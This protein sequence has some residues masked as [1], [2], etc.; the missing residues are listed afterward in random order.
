MLA[1]NYFLDIHIHGEVRLAHTVTYEQIQSALK[2]LWDYTR[3]K[4]F[5]EGVVSLYSSEEPGI[6]REKE[7]LYFCWSVLGDRQIQTVIQEVCM[8][9]NDLSQ[10]ASILEVTLCP[11]LPDDEYGDE[12]N[13][14]QEM[15]EDE[16]FVYYVGPDP[17]AI[18]I[19]QRSVVM[20]EVLEI[21]Q[22]HFDISELENV[23]KEVD[24]LFSK[25]LHT[26][27]KALNT[28]STL[29]DPK[30]KSKTCL[31]PGKKLGKAHNKPLH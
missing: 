18:A 15:Y 13:I 7:T 29:S 23:V 20:E 6:Y 3:A 5:D 30:L 16:I 21:L 11:I 4:T 17:S 8:N 31:L 24:K 28:Y 27:R 10:Q 2:P 9:L 26:L 25:R 19:L 12:T 14:E 22:D 1:E